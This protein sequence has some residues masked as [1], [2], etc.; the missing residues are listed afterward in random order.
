VTWVILTPA[1]QP[2]DVTHIPPSERALIEIIDEVSL[3][4]VAPPHGRG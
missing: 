4:L 3:P 2:R 1:T